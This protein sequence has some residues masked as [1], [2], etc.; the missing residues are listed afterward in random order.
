MKNKFT[1]LISYLLQ[2]QFPNWYG[3]FKVLDYMALKDHIGNNEIIN[4]CFCYSFSK[5][6]KYNFD[7]KGDI[8]YPELIGPTEWY[9]NAYWYDYNDKISRIEK[10]DEANL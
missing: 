4:K 5:L 10:L 8:N 3:Q 1:R 9:S 6:F 2:N 7:P